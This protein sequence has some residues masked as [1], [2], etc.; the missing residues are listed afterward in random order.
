MDLRHLRAFVAVADTGGFARAAA[1]LHLSQPALSRQIAALE[2]ELDVRLFDRVGRGSRL[3]SE[4]EDLLRRARRLVGEADA[5]GARASALRGGHTGILRVGATPQ[6]LENL[7]AHF[8]PPY[9]HGHPGVEVRLIED[10]AARLPARLDRGDIHFAI[11]QAG[12]ARFES[13]PLFPM[14]LLAVPPPGHRLGR[15]AACDVADLADEPLLV[16]RREFRSREWLEA[17]C[18]LA[19]VRPPLLL[20]SGV[21]HTLLALA[22]AGLGIAVVPSNVVVGAGDRAVGLLQRGQADR[23]LGDDRVE[24]RAAPAA[25]CGGLRRRAGR[26]RAA[27]VP[28]SRPRPPRPDV[29]GARVIAPWRAG[30]RRP[31]I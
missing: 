18:E 27:R 13:R 28:R 4:G 12:D 7:L 1:R 11:M 24:P 30:R 5:L 22:R 10:G 17:A 2:G 3:T 6:N 15:R 23:P 19:H 25:L 16:L 21:P 20:E 31:V 29:A 8:L 9:R 14:R 26:A